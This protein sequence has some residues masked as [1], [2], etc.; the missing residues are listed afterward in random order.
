MIFG[1]DYKTI[2][3]SGLFNEQ[4]YLETYPDTRRLDIDIL[5]HFIKNGWKERQNPSQSFDTNFYLETYNDVKNA[6][7]NPLVHFVRYGQKDGRKYMVKIV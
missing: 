1:G 5:D 2:K 4:Y 7:V 6:E 3:K